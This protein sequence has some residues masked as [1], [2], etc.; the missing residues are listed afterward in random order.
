MAKSWN[1]WTD[2]LL[3]TMGVLLII[4]GL[5]PRKGGDRGKMP[6]LVNLCELMGELVNRWIA[7][8]SLQPVSGFGKLHQKSLCGRQA[9]L[10][11]LDPLGKEPLQRARKQLVGNRFRGRNRVRGTRKKSQPFGGLFCPF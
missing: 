6:R 5:S 11:S 10:P 9:L 4:E 1:R 8:Q 2:L 7:V 3:G